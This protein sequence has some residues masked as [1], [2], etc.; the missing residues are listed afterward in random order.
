MAGSA[1]EG[2]AHECLADGGGDFVE[3]GVASFDLGVDVGHIGTGHEEAG[4][5]RR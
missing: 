3:F 1:L 2:Q 5:G 4:C